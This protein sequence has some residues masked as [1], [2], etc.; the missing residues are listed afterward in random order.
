MPKG[1]NMSNTLSL[2]EITIEALTTVTGGAETVCGTS[3]KTKRR[4]CGDF[5]DM[6]LREK[7]GQVRD[8]HGTYSFPPRS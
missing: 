3:T 6:L 2:V 4:V 8:L 7:T 5:A 1:L